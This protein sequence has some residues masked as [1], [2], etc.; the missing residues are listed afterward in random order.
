MAGQPLPKQGKEED[1]PK[2]EAQSVVPKCFF[3]RFL[4]SADEPDDGHVGQSAE[5]KDQVQGKT[6]TH[7]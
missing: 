6:P 4:L 3:H 1:Q 2:E 5:D 7:D